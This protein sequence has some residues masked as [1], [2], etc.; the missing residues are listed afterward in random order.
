MGSEMCI[1]D[2]AHFMALQDNKL[3]I[4]IFN[5]GTGQGVSV[6]EMI[7][8]FE[9]VNKIDVPY[10]ILPRRQ[11]DVESCYAENKRIEEKLN[12]KSKRNI[13]DICKDAYLLSQQLKK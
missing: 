12:W 13:N 1:R 6:M 5:V 4:E 7:K 9:K 11:G 3:G 8:A 10:K 2:R